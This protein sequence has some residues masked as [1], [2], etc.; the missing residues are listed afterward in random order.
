MTKILSINAGSS[1]LKFQ[2]IQLPEETVL[3]QGLVERIG[4]EEGS[5]TIKF[6][7]SKVKVDKPIADHEVA[8][9]MVLQGII[10][11]NIVDNLQE[12][13]GVGHRVVHGG[14]IY[15]QSVLIDDEVI[16]NIR[17]LSD[18]AP[19]HNP[20]NIVGI[21]AFQQALPSAKHVAVFDTAFHQTMKQEHYLYPI[22]YEYYTDYGIRRYGFHGTSHLFVSQQVANLMGKAP[23][24]INVITCHLGNGAS[25]SAV[26]NGKS[27]NTSM[28]F[29]PLA[30]VMMG[31]RSGDIDPSIITFVMEKCGLTAQQVIDVYNK[32]S[33]MLGLSG[34]S[35]D[36]RDLDAAAKEGNPRAVLTQQIYANRVAAVVGSYF[37]QL[38]KVDAIVF[39]GGIGEN[40]GY[41]RQLILER[42]QL[43]MDL[44]IDYELNR[45]VRGKETLLSN[46]TSK[47]QVWLVPTNEELV[48]ALDT[49]EFVTA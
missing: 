15:A 23:E 28:G 7:G 9:Q 36:A 21:L 19:L 4:L 10:D 43:A 44:S 16:E 37:V 13:Q 29:T 17:K 32:K 30:G 22:P 12:I 39:T 26:E 48:I 49:Y 1:S 34:V 42:L 33:G 2:C 25:I 38:G 24:E 40:D 41:L 35:S 8:A 3:C 6:N 27:V 47:S 31:T 14:E 11:N 46:P 5:F 20:A 45:M 18:L